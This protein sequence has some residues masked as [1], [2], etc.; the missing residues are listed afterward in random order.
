MVGNASIPKNKEVL[1]RLNRA[2]FRPFTAEDVVSKRGTMKIEYPSNTQAK[3]LFALL[4]EHAKVTLS[5]N[6][7]DVLEW[8]SNAYLRST[9][10]HPW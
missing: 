10:S 6:P 5:E 3:K 2:N 9:G 8:H 1:I 4:E 7:I